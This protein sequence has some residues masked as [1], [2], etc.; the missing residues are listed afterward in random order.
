MA[1]ANA[2]LNGVEKRMEFLQEDVMEFLRNCNEQYDV[3][4]VDPRK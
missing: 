1:R 2:K 4:V 3:V